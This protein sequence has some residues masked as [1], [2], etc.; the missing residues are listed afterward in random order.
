MTAFVFVHGQ[1]VSE[2]AFGFMLILSGR[3]GMKLISVISQNEEI[4]TNERSM[5][6]C[7]FKESIL[8]FPPDF[9]LRISTLVK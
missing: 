3:K 4:S 9:G 7:Q 1:R 2:P 8:A 5:K 6:D